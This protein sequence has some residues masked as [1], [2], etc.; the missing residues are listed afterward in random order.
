MYPLTWNKV[1]QYDC[2]CQTLWAGVLVFKIDCYVMNIF[3]LLL[4]LAVSGD[5]PHRQ[6]SHWIG[7]KDTGSLEVTFSEIHVATKNQLKIERRGS[8][9]E[10]SLAQDIS[11]NEKGEISVRWTLSLAS[12]FQQGQAHWSPSEPNIMRVSTQGKSDSLVQ[13]GSDVLLW[14][15]DIDEKMRLAARDQL[16]L[17]ITSFSFPS[18]SISYLELI[19]EKP[20]PAGVFQDSVLY[21][22][23]LKEGASVSQ[24]TSWISPSAGQIKQI[25]SSGG[26]IIIT[27]RKE[28]KQP[29]EFSG[30]AFFE[31][32]IRKLPQIP[33]LAWRDEIRVSGLPELKETPQQKKIDRG[34]YLLSRAAPPNFDEARQLPNRNPVGIDSKDAP[35][36][37]D[38][39]LLGLNDA[40]L[41]GLVAR[42]NVNPDVG[43][44]DLACQV[45]AFVFNLI[46]DKELD[47]GFATAPEVARNPRGDCTEHT[48]L[49]I[50]LLRRL[51]VPARAAIG[52]AG[53]DAG[54][55]TSFGLHS[56]VEV[57]IGSR[58]IPIDP[59][60]DQAPA[61]A[62]RIM[63]GAYDLNS[64][65]ELAWDL[66]P[67]P[68]AAINVK[69]VPLKINEERLVI[70]DTVIKISKGAWKMSN[71]KIWLEHPVLGQIFVNGNIRYLPMRDSKYI[72][73]PGH[74]PARYTKSIHQLAI[75]CGKGKWL[76]FEGL[77]EDSALTILREIKY[78]NS[79]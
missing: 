8:S 63:T 22:G 18:S 30:T 50:A 36:L 9:V 27:Q 19:P 6:F 67:P 13:I 2:L 75:D 56:W 74:P 24:I 26:L 54:S 31:W 3:P 68:E 7:G 17:R 14:P 53:L 66:G 46:R 23:S 41:N 45:N 11:R 76:Y 35:F 28:L 5:D 48:V 1:W 39:P 16:P 21:K 55:E 77:C 40:A 29:N 42:L 71:D 70:D 25:S 32:T 38:S 78:N 61:G 10:Q 57:K 49:A 44:W 59:T 51:G 52:W 65:D 34:E 43:R 58:W 64:I 79:M 72:N 4:C 37:A 62:F 15:P 69:T 60:F 47:V 20:Y 12:R 73:F 33:F